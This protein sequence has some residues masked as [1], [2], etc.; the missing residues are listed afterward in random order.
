MAESFGEEEVIMKANALPCLLRSL[1]ASTVQIDQINCF[2][3]AVQSLSVTSML[4]LTKG[5]EL[6]KLTCALILQHQYSVSLGLLICLSICLFVCL[7]VYSPLRLVLRLNKPGLRPSQSSLRPEAQP[8]R[9]ENKPARP[10]AHKS[11]L[12]A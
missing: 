11:R 12:E 7:P 2:L 3:M 4:W 9:P 10:E 6:Y 5:V 8:T 1:L